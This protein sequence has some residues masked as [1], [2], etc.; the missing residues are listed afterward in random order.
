MLIAAVLAAIVVAGCSSGDD[1][2]LEGVCD[3]PGVTSDEI[4]LGFVISDAEDGSNVFSSA[5]SGLDARIGLANETGGINGRR[6][7]YSW[8]ED[9]FSSSR[10]TLVTKELMKGNSLFGL[11]T[12]TSATGAVVDQLDKEGI[13][14]VGLA[15]GPEWGRRRNMFSVLAN[16]SSEVGSR[17]I[18]ASGGTKVAIL[19]SG[20]GAGAPE[21]I[22]NFEQALKSIGLVSAG[23]IAFSGTVD[24]PTR[25]AQR[26][27]E[28]GVNALAGYST[29]DD[30]AKIMQAVRAANVDIRVTLSMAGYDRGLL[31]T[32]GPALAGVS[33]PVY[34][35]PFEAGGAPI[36]RY[37]EAM[38][39]FAPQA[40]Q[41]EQGFAMY[42]YIYVDLFLRG[43]E[44]AGACPTREG[45]INALRQVTNYDA[46][47]L[48]PPNDLRSQ[49]T[50]TPSRCNAFVQV[51]AAGDAFQVARERFC[52]DGSGS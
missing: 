49:A 11:V 43:L 3:S 18:Q 38:A 34:F 40:I 52:A 32:L 45:F 42:A 17:Y 27:G 35:R 37:R 29:P 4:K 8:R 5:R 31:P 30:L 39:R 51:N 26:L 24:S 28:L 33:I 50:G 44:L 2:K 6:I 15:N 9:E 14:V 36:D 13:P 22:A 25:V 23:T 7:T 10:N 47:G 12:V 48:I 20:S 41:A 19:T 16:P 1:S 46:G 21:K